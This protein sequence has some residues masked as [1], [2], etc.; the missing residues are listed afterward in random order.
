MSIEIKVPSLGESETEAT[1]IAWLKKEG[2]AVAVDDVLAEIESDKITMEITA[3]DAGVLKSVLKKVDDIV[4]PGE[5]IGVIDESVQIEKSDVKAATAEEV[6]E[7]VVQPVVEKIKPTV[8][9]ETTL[10]DEE[11]DS[12]SEAVVISRPEPP[13]SSQ[14]VEERVPMTRLRKRIAERLKSAQNTA[15][16]LTTFN[17][18]NLQAVMDLRT[19]YGARFQEKHGVKLGFMS[20]FVRAVSQAISQYPAL[21]A[22][23]EAE[24][25]VYHNYVDV[26]IAVSTDKGLVVPVLRDAHLMGLA[27]IEKGIADLAGKARD[28]GL[29]PHDL[30]GGTFSITN[31]GIYGSM[32]STPILNPPQSGILGMH[33]IQKRTMVENDAVV[34]R[35][36]MYLALSYDHRLIDGADAVRFLVAVKEALEYPAGLTLN[37]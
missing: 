3:L 30:K 27:E 13:V 35:P 34:I 26:G 16:M 25:I 4:E 12:N 18:V 31:G 21:N 14:R 32:L 15:A 7:E 29:T 28:G 23:I 36:M 37:L 2:D 9:V 20:F 10:T 17:E 5:V 6:S 8:V 33:N 19:R 22:Y 1:L 11:D 24:D